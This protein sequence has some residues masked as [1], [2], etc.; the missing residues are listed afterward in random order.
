MFW[1]VTGGSAELEGTEGVSR[2]RDGGGG[3][4]PPT[5]TE[6]IKPAR[7]RLRH[8]DRCRPERGMEV[9]PRRALEAFWR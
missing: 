6:E 9:R 1:R 7:W 5:D 4:G 3:V 8:R 2:I